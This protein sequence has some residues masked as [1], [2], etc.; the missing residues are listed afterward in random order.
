MCVYVCVWARVRA[1]MKMP[2]VVRGALCK[3]GRPKVCNA[4]ANADWEQQAA[5]A[6]HMQNSINIWLPSPSPPPS[7]LHSLYAGTFIEWLPLHATFG[8]NFRRRTASSTASAA[9]LHSCNFNSD[10][11]ISC[12]WLKGAYWTQ[13]CKWVKFASEWVEA[14]DESASCVSSF[15]YAEYFAGSSS[16]DCRDFWVNMY[17]CVCVRVCVCTS[18]YMCIFKLLPHANSSRIPLCSRSVAYS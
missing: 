12:A 7:H 13:I 9:Q 3:R 16:S 8:G 10:S 15:N 1:C 17:E 11:R 6:W 5:V 2:Y 4:N 14:R 18:F